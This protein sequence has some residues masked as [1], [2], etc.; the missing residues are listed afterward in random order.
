M[1]R[2]SSVGY[3]PDK[4]SPEVILE[5]RLI[6]VADEYDVPF[7]VICIEARGAGRYDLREGC[8]YTVEKLALGPMFDELRVRLKEFSSTWYATRFQRI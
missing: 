5:P 4:G 8:T 3:T 6:T 2:K 7:L 1:P